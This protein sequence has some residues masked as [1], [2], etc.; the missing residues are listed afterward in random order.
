MADA[1]GSL[2][3]FVRFLHLGMTTIAC[4]PQEAAQQFEIFNDGA[5]WN[6]LRTSGSVVQDDEQIE[7]CVIPGQ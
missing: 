1:T 7:R 6:R 5:A 2:E 4:S 3:R